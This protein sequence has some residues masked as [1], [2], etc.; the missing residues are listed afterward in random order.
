VPIRHI[1]IHGDTIEAGI[2]T[3]GKPPAAVGGSRR[4]GR[5]EGEANMN[6]PPCSRRRDDLVFENGTISVKASPASASCSRARRM[7][8]SLSRRLGLGLDSD[9]AFFEPSTTH[10]FG[11]HISMIEI[12]RDR[13][14]DALSSLPWTMQKP[15]QSALSRQIMVA[16]R[17]RAG[18]DSKGRLRRIA[19]S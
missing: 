10:P 7:P 2:G 18:D 14:A 16:A 17:D 6:S 13:R 1:T 15:H 4:N 9:E 11:C 8:T 12:D 5:N 19:N 3:P